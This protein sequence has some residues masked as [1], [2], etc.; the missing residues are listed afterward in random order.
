MSERRVGVLSLGARAV[1]VL[2]GHDPD[3]RAY[4][5]LRMR[6]AERASMA[7]RLG[8]RMVADLARLLGAAGREA[9][10]LGDEDGD[11]DEEQVDTVRAGG[12][13]VQIWRLV[14]RDDWR[15]VELRICI[16]DASPLRVRFGPV[17]LARL[18]VRLDRLGRETWGERWTRQIETPEQ[19]TTRSGS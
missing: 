12:V 13:R 5:S 14:G 11:H 8:P 1:D 17:A 6:A 2:V 19:T 16:S 3:G 4:V 15:S 9:F 18:V 7:V 10:G